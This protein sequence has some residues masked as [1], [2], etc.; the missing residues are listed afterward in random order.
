MSKNAV[1]GKNDATDGNHTLNKPH[2]ERQFEEDALI[3]RVIEGYCMSANARFTLNSAIVD[4]EPPQKVNDRTSIANSRVGNSETVDDR[5][6]SETVKIL[7]G[8]M[9]D[10]QTQVAQLC[11]QLE[12]ER[13]SRLSLAATVKRSMAVI[14]GTVP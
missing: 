11:K 3:L 1:A 6:L 5:Y 9:M 8:Q 4:F 14:D 12:E 10:I 2:N 13:K 7:K